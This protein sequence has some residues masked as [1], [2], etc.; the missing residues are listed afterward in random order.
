QTA[1][2][3][4]LQTAAA[5]NRARRKNP[6]PKPAE[7][8]YRWEERREEGLDVIYRLTV[9]R[10]AAGEGRRLVLPARAQEACPR[11]LGQGRILAKLGDNGL[12]RPSV[13]PKCAGRGALERPINLAVTIT[14]EQVGRSRM[15]LRGAGLYQAAQARRGDLI[16]ERTWADRLAPAN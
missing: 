3:K 7:Q 6:K 5:H 4:L 2:K 10:P 8:P 12:Y 1:Y 15:R 11:C 13:C 14:A 16:L 9:L